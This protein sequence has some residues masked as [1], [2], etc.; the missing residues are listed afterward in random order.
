MAREITIFDCHVGS[1]IPNIGDMRV[2]VGLQALGG[3]LSFQA[4]NFT[5][6]ALKIM[7]G[8]LLGPEL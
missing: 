2:Y 5:W 6:N 7:Y 8:D 1:H 3:I 4:R